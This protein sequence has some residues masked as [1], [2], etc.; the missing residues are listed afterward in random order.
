MQF[1]IRAISCSVFD[2]WVCWHV[3]WKDRQ[4]AGQGQQQP[5]ADL[6]CISDLY[7]GINRLI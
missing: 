4:W 7:N 3:E 1:Q 5:Y 6:R 2:K